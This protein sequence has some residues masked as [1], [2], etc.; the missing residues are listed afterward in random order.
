MINI[1][2]LKINSAQADLQITFEPENNC[3][4]SFEYLRVFS[5][6]KEKDSVE[7]GKFSCVF[8]KKLVK[9]L[10][11]ELVGKHGYRF[12][13]DDNHSAI[14]SAEYLYELYQ[15]QNERWQLYL[16]ETNA[17]N[18]SREASINFKEV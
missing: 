9:L 17:S 6:K 5:P 7:I 3:Q 13:F 15:E 11:I 18:K 14:Y 4:Y 8:H 12:I 16:T 1:S 2:H 10:N